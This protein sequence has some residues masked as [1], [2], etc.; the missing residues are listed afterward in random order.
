MPVM[1]GVNVDHVAT[2]REARGLGYPDPVSAAR[3][4]AEAGA[5]MVVCHLRQDR[6]HIQ[7]ADVVRL[8]KLSGLPVHLEMSCSAEMERIALRIKPA[9]VCLVPESPKEKTTQGGLDLSPRNLPRVKAL[10]AK[11]KKAGIEVSIFADAEADAVRACKKIGA[12]TVELCTK[13]Y[14]E[15]PSRK[16]E[17]V[18]LEKLAVASVLVRELGLHLHSGHGLDYGNVG[19]VA[20]IPGMECLNIG[21]SIMAKSVFV[22]LGSAVAEMKGII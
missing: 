22:G 10:T 20:R 5:D 16:K 3:I 11:L 12:D 21:F 6:R 2:L 7:D 14:A 8:K 4:C 15:A 18:E 17:A 19:P 9:S 1:L 13:A